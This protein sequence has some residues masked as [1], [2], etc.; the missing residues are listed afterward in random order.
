MPSSSSRCK[1]RAASSSPPG[2]LAAVRALCTS[3]GA[4]MLLDEVQTGMGRTGT[5]FAYQHHDAV[6]DGLSTAKGLAGGVPMGAILVSEELARGFE[7]GTHA[8]TFGGNLLASA[9]ALATVGVMDRDGLCERA[10]VMGAKLGVALDR[11]VQDDRRL[12]SRPGGRAC[13]A[14]SRRRRGSTRPRSSRPVASVACCSRWRGA[15]WSALAAA[16]RVGGGAGRGGGGARRR[17]RR[18]ASG[19]RT[20]P[21]GSVRT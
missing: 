19:C 18:S 3:R 2:Y 5:F 20:P 13:S 10:R 16:E 21:G 4:L 6:P 12:R 14:D 7:P 9:A 11:L 1:A 17:A 8:S 15:A